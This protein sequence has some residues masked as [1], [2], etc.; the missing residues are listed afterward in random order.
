MEGAE[1]KVSYCD[2]L[3]DL[4]GQFYSLYILSK[5]FKVIQRNKMMVL[6]LKKKKPT[7][8]DE[9]SNTFRKYLSAVLYLLMKS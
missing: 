9:A 1:S 5:L 4:T 3:K 2:L 8:S 6:V 7:E